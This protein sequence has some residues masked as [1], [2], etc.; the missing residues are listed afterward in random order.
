MNHDKPEVASRAGH[1][2]MAGDATTRESV[3]VK[4]FSIAGV[5]MDSPFVLAPLAATNVA[6]VA[7]IGYLPP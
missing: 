4:P 1:E 6:L 2:S 5:T 3:E 7:A